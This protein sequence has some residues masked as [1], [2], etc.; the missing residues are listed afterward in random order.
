MSS[1][2]SLV[3]PMVLW[4]RYAPTHCVSAILMTPDGKYIVTG[5]NDGQIVV[6]DVLE[7]FQVAARNMLFGHTAAISCLAMGSE[8]RERCY[9]VSSSENG[10][11][12]LW[13]VSDGRCIENNKM[14]KVH[15]DIAAYH[16]K[17][18]KALRL[19]CNGY[20]DEI[21]IIDPLNLEIVYLL[22]A[23]VESDWISACCIITPP[24]RD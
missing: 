1:G 19:V 4:G 7:H 15:S 9:I 6:W 24:N 5:C 20:Y 14:D 13:D 11:M 8:H 16:L 21:V 2:S 3:V 22:V 10:E 18:A 23:R 12:C 17:S